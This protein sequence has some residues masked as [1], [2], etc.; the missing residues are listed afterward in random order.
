[1][2]ISP[3]PTSSLV[4]H[5]PS[6]NL[7]FLTGFLLIFGLATHMTTLSVQHSNTPNDDDDDDDTEYGSLTNMGIDIQN[8]P[9][10]SR[11]R[12]KTKIP[13]TT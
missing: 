4:P 2:S 3:F 10:S 7:I 13:L 12:R 9:N 8:E 1:M 5:L 6:Q 11:Q